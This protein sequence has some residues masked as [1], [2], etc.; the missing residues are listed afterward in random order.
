[1]KTTVISFL[2]AFILFAG[3]TFNTSTSVGLS[4]EKSQLAKKGEGQNLVLSEDGV[5]TR[6]ETVNYVLS[7]VGKFTQDENG[8]CW[9]DMDLAV[10]DMDNN[11]IFSADSLLGDAGHVALENGVASSPYASYNTDSS[12]APGKYRIKIKI[13]DRLGKGRATQSAVF[14][15]R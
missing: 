7:N 4:V 12:M 10:T 15:L 1:M 5:F 6:G 2:G 9:M 3:C 11:I 13:Y 14:E 8:L